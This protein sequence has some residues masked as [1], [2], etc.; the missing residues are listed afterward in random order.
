MLLDRNGVPDKGQKINQVNGQTR[1]WTG[2]AGL[3]SGTACPYQH[4]HA[5]FPGSL[6]NA[7][8]GPQVCCDLC[9]PLGKILDNDSSTPSHQV[10]GTIQP[11][12]GF[13][14]SWAALTLECLPQCLGAERHH[15]RVL[16]QHYSSKWAV[17]TFFIYRPRGCALQYH[18]CT[19]A[20][21][22]PTASAEPTSYPPT[23]HRK[24]PSASPTSRLG[25]SSGPAP[26]WTSQGHRQ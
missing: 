22:V 4:G 26:L 8:F 5:A 18:S 21:P 10:P 9:S 23:W 19:V 15:T 14:S 11:T 1:G 12:T 20:P 17:R 13:P 16:H 2:C 7:M 25:A 3:P 24:R 6:Q